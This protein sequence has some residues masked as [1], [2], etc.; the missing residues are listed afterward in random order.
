MTPPVVYFAGKVAP[1]DW[2]H[3]LADLRR[4]TSSDPDDFPVLPTYDGWC[5]Y[6]GPFFLSC[7][8]SCNHGVSS[9][10]ML[11]SGCDIDNRHTP[12]DVVRLCLEWLD[13]ADLLFVWLDATDAAGTIAEMGYAMAMG[14]PIYLYEPTGFSRPPWEPF[15]AEEVEYDPHTG[16]DA[17]E[18]HRPPQ[19][20][21]DDLWFVRELTTNRVVYCDG[22]VQ[23][24]LRIFRR[25]CDAFIPPTAAVGQ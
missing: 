12:T 16:F 17:V 20:A 19:R 23:E 11:N 21:G 8:H 22:G 25:V 6:G 24:A 4:R 15:V 1:L 10:G 3:S 7:D 18:V 14:I 13:R 9:H 5:G 2:R